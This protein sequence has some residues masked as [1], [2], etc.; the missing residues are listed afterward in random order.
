MAKGFA[1]AANFPLAR[2]SPG[3]EAASMPVGPARDDPGAGHEDDG[4]LGHGRAGDTA[5]PFA[6]TGPWGHRGRMRDKL[7]G[8]GPDALADYEMLEMLL[9]LALPR[10]DTKPLAKAVINRFGSFA[11]V[12]AAP[13]QALRATPGLNTQAVVALKLAHASALR[14]ARSEVRERPVLADWD[15]LM[16]YLGMALTRDGEGEVRV[17]FLDSRNRL[18]ADEA[19]EAGPAIVAGPHPREVARRA[20]ELHATALILVRS[21][22]G[23]DPV[24]SPGEVQATARLREAAQALSIV[25]HDHVILGRGRWLSFRAEGLL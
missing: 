3:G 11:A 1:D 20:L 18:L 12:L 14:L 15:A 6:S 24:A 2:Q 16:G 5:L 21:R 8:R 10:G 23:C 7:L 4:P 25:V 9:F 22:P 17:L 13:D 19:Q